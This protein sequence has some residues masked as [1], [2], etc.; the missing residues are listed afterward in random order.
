ME[1]Y[2]LEFETVGEIYEANDR[3]RARLLKI[4]D[5]ITPE[6]Q[7]LRTEKGDWT[8]AGIVEHLARAEQG[9]AKVAHHLLKKAEE[10]SAGSD[11]KAG[12]SEEFRNNV[13]EW[14]D[15]KAKAPE[16]VQP[17]TETGIAEWVSLLED[18]RKHLAAMRERFE[19]VDGRSLTFPHPIFGPI[20]A[21]EWLALIGAHESR[22]IE[23]IE[24]LLESGS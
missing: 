16:M 10:K 13:R 21:Q 14:R 24:K 8:V 4:L 5:E 12:I 6:Q 22:H 20:T 23:Q 18:N 3:V 15:S 11:G 9:M 17:N 7:A 2:V 1:E 19:S